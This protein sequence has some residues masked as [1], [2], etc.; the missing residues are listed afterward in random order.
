[1][2][3]RR[4][5][6]ADNLVGRTVVEEECIAPDDSTARED[7]IGDLALLLILLERL[8][9]RV[10]RARD[11]R[12]TRGI[13][14]RGAETVGRVSRDPVINHQPFVANLD[15]WRCAPDLLAVPHPSPG[16]YN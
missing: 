6:D 9:D 11:D 3:E 2:R 13:K 12:R 1:M 4:G 7:D 5:R 10:G 15:R 8:K 16:T 14:E